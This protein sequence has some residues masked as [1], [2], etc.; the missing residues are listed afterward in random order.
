MSG[1]YPEAVSIF[2]GSASLRPGWGVATAGRRAVIAVGIPLAVF[3]IAATGPILSSTILGFLALAIF[4][5]LSSRYPEFSVLG[6]IVWVPLQLPVL[7]YFFKL[8]APAL[9]VKDLGFLKEFWVI[10]LVITVVR[11]GGLRRKFDGLD[12]AVTVVIGLTTL[13]LLL[14]LAGGGA[15]GG[16]PFWPRLTAWRLEVLGLLIFFCLRRLRLRSGTAQRARY[17]VYFVAVVMA[18][19]GFWE[20]ASASGFTTFIGSTLAY[21]TFKAVVLHVTVKGPVLTYGDAGNSSFV[22]VGSV[23]ND[24]LALGF[25]MLIPLALG[26]QGLG[27]RKGAILGGAI[28]GLSVA[29]VL[30]TVTRAAVLGMSALIVLAVLVG[31]SRLSPSRLRVVIVI[32]LAGVIMLPSAGHSDIVGRF[33]SIFDSQDADTQGHI[34]A[35]RAA[36]SALVKRPQGRGLGSDTSIGNRFGTANVITAENSYLEIGNDIGVVGMLAFLAALLT[37]LRALRQR[38]REEVETAGLAGAV[39]LAGCGLLIGGM[40]L[41]TWTMITINLMFWPLAGLALSV[42]ESVPDLPRRTRRRPRSRRVSQTNSGLRLVR[43][44]SLRSGWVASGD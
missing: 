2:G 22:R 3:G 21:P 33:H 29:T 23:L 41:Q 37:A 19:F 17:G 11:R 12:W 28:A 24:P 42:P 13:Y 16:V 26:L 43:A 5:G 8:G 20:S 40:F 6:L 44:H 10:S 1:S 35:T 9:V 14:P 7:A 15:L 27:S 30:M 32:A 4:L 38:S 36:A 34:S 25:L 39:W 18:A 31:V